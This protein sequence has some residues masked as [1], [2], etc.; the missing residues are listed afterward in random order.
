ME[1][2]L[3]DTGPVRVRYGALE[4]PASG[5]LRRVDARNV[6]G[7]RQTERCRLTFGA[8]ASSVVAATERRKSLRL[9]APRNSR[10]AAVVSSFGWRHGTRAAKSRLFR[11]ATT[12]S[13]HALAVAASLLG[14]TVL[15]RRP[16][17]IWLADI[18][19]ITPYVTTE[20]VRHDRF[21]DL[22]RSDDREHRHSP[23][24]C[25]ILEPAEL[26]AHNP[27]PILPGEEQV[28]YPPPSRLETRSAAGK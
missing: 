5:D 18:R 1:R 27:E 16:G 25:I 10:S 19:Y 2:C 6:A 7:R 8:F 4:V 11:V 9:G 20:A 21:A 24:A 17:H 13:N 15:V 22:E 3:R 14:Q 23:S 28:S 12:D 26:Q